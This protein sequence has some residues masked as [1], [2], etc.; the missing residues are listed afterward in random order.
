[1]T[2]PLLC[3]ATGAMVAGLGMA[4]ALGQHH[5]TWPLQGL[6]GNL[7]TLPVSPD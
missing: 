1:M 6:R 7:L 5:T 2:L 4:W 3:F